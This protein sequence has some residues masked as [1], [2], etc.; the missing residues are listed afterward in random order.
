MLRQDASYLN[1]ILAMKCRKHKPA[2]ILMEIKLAFRD[3][4]YWRQA[5][6]TAFK[7]YE[8]S[9]NPPERLSKLPLPDEYWHALTDWGEMLPDFVYQAWRMEELLRLT[10]QKEDSTDPAWAAAEALMAKLTKKGK[11]KYAYRDDMVQDAFRAALLS[12]D[13]TKS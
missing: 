4:V 8:P 13:P 12:M 7:I 11:S 1:S 5:C 6:L 10:S 9:C 3:M 2:Q